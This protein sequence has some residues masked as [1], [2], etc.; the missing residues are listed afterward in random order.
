MTRTRALPLGPVVVVMRNTASQIK[1]RSLLVDHQGSVS[2]IVTDSTGASLVS[3]SFTAYGNRREASTWSGAPTSGELTT[4]NGVTREGYTF[5]TVLGSM[6]LI[7][8]NGRIEDSVTGRFLSPDPQGTIGGNTQSWNRYSYVNNNP[9]TYVDPTGFDECNDC[10]KPT[11]GSP[12]P[13][14][15]DSDMEEIVVTSSASHSTVTNFAPGGYTATAPDGSEVIF[16]L[17]H[18]PGKGS[19]GIQAQ[20]PKPISPGACARYGSPTVC[21]PAPPCGIAATASLGGGGVAALFAGASVD[22]RIGVNTNGQIYIQATGGIGGGAQAGGAGSV[23]VSTGIQSGSLP[24]GPSV[25]SGSSVLVQGVYGL[26]GGQSINVG[27][28]GVDFGTD[29][30]ISAGEFLSAGALYAQGSLIIATPTM[31]CTPEAK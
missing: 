10:V 22:V 26:G 15:K 12:P 16:G 30:R 25:S 23:F 29:T 27:R 24:V 9:L 28:D 19:S 13:E 31:G 8:M 7:H 1:V 4:M 11:D 6:G 5:Q 3:E 14:G 21:A 18:K 20:S 17:A 2:S